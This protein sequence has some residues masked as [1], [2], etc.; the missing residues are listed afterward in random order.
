[1]SYRFRA[2]CTQGDK[3]LVA[4][5]AETSAGPLVL[6][7]SIAPARTVQK[8]QRSQRA[9]PILEAKAKVSFPTEA[10]ACSDANEVYENGKPIPDPKRARCNVRTIP[11]E[12]TRHAVDED[13]NCV[14]G[15]F[16]GFALVIQWEN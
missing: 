1:M 11:P 2:T 3:D 12:L 13:G 16:Q 7:A 4:L 6:W 14:L 10:K 5:L 9:V 15:R 8:S